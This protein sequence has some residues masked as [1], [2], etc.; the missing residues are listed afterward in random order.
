MNQISQYFLR[1][2]RPRMYAFLTRILYHDKNIKIG[3]NFRA[4]SIPK[5]I[6]DNGSKLIIGNNVEFRRNIEIRVHK[7]SE[8]FIGNDCRIDRGVRLLVSNGAS[9]IMESKVRV[10]LYTVFNGGDSIKIGAGAL[11]SGFVYIQT[12]MHGHSNSTLSFQDQGYTHGQVEIGQNVWIGTHAIVLP[13]I[14]VG[15]NA[16]IGSNAVVTKNIELGDVVAGVPAKS[17][18][19]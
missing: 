1:E 16:I 5:I 11:I 2:I 14:S 17:I 19:K 4:D 9:I 7:S 13:G 15:K 10:G 3:N 6:F 12:S 18:K 8:L